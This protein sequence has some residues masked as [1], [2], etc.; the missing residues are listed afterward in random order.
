MDRNFQEKILF[1]TH[2]RK[3]LPHVAVLKNFKTFFEKIHLFF[4][5][6]PK[7]ATFW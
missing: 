7:F 5:K 2:S 3:K 4:Q 1:E 6:K